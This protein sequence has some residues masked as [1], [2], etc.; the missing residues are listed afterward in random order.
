MN[1]LLI[2]R[3]FYMGIELMALLCEITIT[4]IA[5]LYFMI[6]KRD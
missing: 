4:S 6:V 3:L 5:F 1:N 2:G